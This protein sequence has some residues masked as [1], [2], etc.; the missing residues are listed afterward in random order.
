M[1]APSYTNDLTDIATGDEAT[2]WI[3][4]STNQQGAPAYQDSD[5]PYIQGSYSVTQDCAKSKTIGNLG[6]DYGSTISL[7]TDGA[8]L[9]WQ[10]FSTP[11]AIDTEA[12][13]TTGTGGMAVIVGD[14]A[15]NFSFWEVGG[16]DVSPYPYGGWVNHAVNTTVTADGTTGTKTIDRYV[17]AQVALVAY[18]SKGEPHCVDAM[19][20][21]RCSAIFEDGDFAN[22]YCT[23]AGFA[24]QND[25]QSNRWGLIQKVAGGY[26][27]KGRMLL[28]DNT[29]NPCDFQD[30]DT[31]IFIQYTPKVTA[32]FNTI[33]VQN[34][35][36]NVVMTGISFI[37]LDTG[38][39][40]R[41]RFI[42]TD[43]ATVFLI[44]CNFTDMDT[45][46]FDSNSTVD[47]CNFVRC[48]TITQN[49][50]LILDS[51][52]DSSI[53]T[54]AMVV[55]ILGFVQGN[56]FVSDGTGHAVDLGNITTTQ[57]LTWDNILDD[58]SGTEWTGVTGSPITT[59]TTGNEAILC[60]V[61]SGQ[62]LTISVASGASIP[63][64]KNDGTGSVNVVANQVTTTITVQDASV[65]PPATITDQ[66]V[67]VY[68]EAG[69]GGPLT[70]G[71][72]IIKSFTNTSGQVSDT[73]TLASNQPITGWAR[74]ASPG[75]GA[76][77]SGT[78]YFKETKIT[79]TISST[80]G[81]DLTILLQQDE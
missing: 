5:Y 58:G 31:N 65:S 27:W 3:N 80:N 11:T 59:G 33:E 34:A 43:D 22:G 10:N 26:L 1:A 61:S 52:I 24:A 21:G 69:T 16:S 48:G 73:R 45:F 39:A 53:D 51:T 49:G 28:G 47:G 71:T 25:N 54:T 63:T 41:G 14:D 8:F 70:A 2:G 38:T 57:T 76:L 12:G 55:D 15:S 42:V 6:Y 36:S 35:S 9:V 81:L 44:N 62:T 56:T 13:T 7:P 75:A 17:G 66:S 32:N 37:C 23:F 72:Q 79:G 29:N 77:P 60:N 64:V 46:S 50:A 20:F 18:P 30:S 74:R 78:T 67:N 4:F 19:R 40:S 68:I